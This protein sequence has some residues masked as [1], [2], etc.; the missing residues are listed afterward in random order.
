MHPKSQMLNF[1]GAFMAF[2]LIMNGTCP[3]NGRIIGK[4][5]QACYNTST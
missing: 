1:W 5:W 3:K 4:D 2:S